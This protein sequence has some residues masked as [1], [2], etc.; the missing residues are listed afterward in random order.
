MKRQAANRV[1]VS[2]QRE[3]G[4][5]RF[6]LIRV[7]YS[8]IIDPTQANITIINAYSGQL[9][10]TGIASERIVLEYFRAI[11]KRKAIELLTGCSGR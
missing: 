8:L 9:A 5:D 4:R 10:Q 2:S 6:S 3:L 7:Y 1:E 11:R